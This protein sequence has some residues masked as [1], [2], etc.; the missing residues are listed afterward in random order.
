MLQNLEKRKY[1]YLWII[2]SLLLSLCVIVPY[3][4]TDKIVAG[5]DWLFHA[6]RVEE[7]YQNLQHGKVLTFISTRTFSHSG[8]GTFLFYPTFFF[9]PWVL[10]RFLFNPILS[11]YLWIALITWFALLVSYF[12]MKS[13]SSNGKVSV[14]FALLYVFNSYRIYLSFWPF[15]EFV[16]AT[17]LP[18]VFLAFYRMFFDSKKHSKYVPSYMLLG[19]SMALL[20]YAHLVSAFITLEIF[21]TILIIFSIFGNLKQVISK[22]K[23]IMLS[24]LIAIILCLPIIWLFATNYIK[25]D[26]SSTYFGINMNLVKPLFEILQNSIN[27][28]SGWSI[29]FPLVIILATGWFYCRNKPTLMYIYLSGAFLLLMSSSMFPWWILKNS[30]LGVIQMPYRYLSYASLF[31]AVVGS[32]M[33]YHV[34]SKLLVTEHKQNVFMILFILGTLGFYT[35]AIEGSYKLSMITNPAHLSRARTRK[36]LPNLT[37]LDKSNYN[38]QFNYLIPWGETDYYPNK[39]LAKKQNSESIMKGITY[40]GGQKLGKVKADYLPNMI[41]YT[42]NLSKPSSLDLPCIAYHHTYV[43]LNG[44]TISY[45]ISSRGTVLI[46]FAETKSGKVKISVGFNPGIPYYICMVITTI[47]WILIP[48]DC[49]RRKKVNG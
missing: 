32:K 1:D 22:W 15:G 42:I 17:I 48:L 26:I 47:A 18:L 2:G 9:Y 35:V 11:F 6:S 41:M 30:F 27:G 40:L 44:K 8:S 39:S 33:I 3:L 14:I 31:L 43:K 13:F 29:G 16:A 5:S 20:I 21:I 38:N 12:S 37:I 34:L 49:I 10:L 46:P 19:I 4:H 28:L 36:K 25:K 45:K 24:I 23:E 7:M